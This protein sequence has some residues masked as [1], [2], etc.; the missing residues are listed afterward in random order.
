MHTLRT[1]VMMCGVAQLLTRLLLIHFYLVVFEYIIIMEKCYFS[2]FSA[3]AVSSLHGILNAKQ[4]KKISLFVCFSFSFSGRL[5]FDSLLFIILLIFLFA[6][7]IS[8]I[9]TYTVYTE[10][11]LSPHSPSVHAPCNEI[12]IFIL[13]RHRRRSAG[14]QWE[15]IF[16]IRVPPSLR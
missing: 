14:L 9:C 2:F 15:R 11:L 13:S 4:V 16:K 3:A 1:I 5:H 6:K 12:Y 7:T 10:Y 8:L